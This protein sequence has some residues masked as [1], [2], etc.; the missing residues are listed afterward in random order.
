MPDLRPF[1]PKTN[2]LAVLVLIMGALALA[3]GGNA[4]VFQLGSVLN[5]VPPT[6]TAPWLTATFVTVS[7]GTVTLILQAHL[8]ISSEF[9]GEVGLNLNP[10]ISPSAMHFVQTSGPP[11]ASV[12][13]PADQNTA[14]LP[15]GGALGRG[16]DVLLDWPTASKQDRFDGNET[17]LLTITGPPTLLAQDFLFFNTINGSDGAALIGAHVQGIPLFGDGTGSSAIL[18]GTTIPE[19]ST[20]LFFLCGACFLGLLRNRKPAPPQACR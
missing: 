14:D 20:S 10:N 8:N 15:G 17:A 6:S 19:P 7:P 13:Q 4:Q 9:I 11:F 12:V 3:I 1:R 18:Q 16:F 5:G 2:R